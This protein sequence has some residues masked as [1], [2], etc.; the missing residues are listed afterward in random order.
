MFA[1]TTF[2]TLPKNYNFHHVTF[3]TFVSLYIFIANQATINLK[4]NI[5]IDTKVAK[6]NVARFVAKV[7]VP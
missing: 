3:A 2:A 6:V 7:I 1:A 4:L 5:F